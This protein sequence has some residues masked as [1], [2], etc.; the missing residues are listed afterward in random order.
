LVARVARDVVD[1]VWAGRDGVGAGG[2]GLGGAESEGES[3]GAVGVAPGSGGG[4]VEDLAGV[5]NGAV[6]GVKVFADVPAGW[7]LEFAIFESGPEAWEEFGFERGGELAEFETSGREL[8][9]LVS[10][11]AELVLLLKYIAEF[12]LR[13]AESHRAS[14]R[15]LLHRLGSG[16]S[17]GKGAADGT[18][19]GAGRRPA[20]PIPENQRSANLLERPL[21]VE[22]M[23]SF[24]GPPRSGLEMLG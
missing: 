10:V 6:E 17:R 24:F 3:G 8:P 1:I 15:R 13:I 23:R 5:R 14:S 22:M 2:D 7:N 21:G 18:S 20:L 4:A 9:K 12:G 11:I 19:A 16:A